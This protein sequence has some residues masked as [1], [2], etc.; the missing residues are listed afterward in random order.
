VTRVHVFGGGDALRHGPAD[1]LA[2]TYFFG[3]GV[4]HHALLQCG[5][6]FG[7][8]SSAPFLT[9][10]LRGDLATHSCWHRSHLYPGTLIVISAMPPTL[11][12]RCNRV[13]VT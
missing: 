12:T 8:G 9:F 5:Q 11:P 4:S 3:G 7:L 13:K 6:I 2:G 1:R 10:A